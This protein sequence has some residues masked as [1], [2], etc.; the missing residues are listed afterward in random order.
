MDDRRSPLLGSFTVVVAACLFAM[1]GVLSRIAYDQGLTPYAFVTWRSGVAALAVAV[2]VLVSLR[3]GRRLVGWR[4]LTS[5]DRVALGVA[6]L[7]GASLDVTMFLAFARVPVAI[8]LLCFYLFP[9]MV[10]VGSALLGW[11]RIDRP[12]AMALVIALVGMVAVVIGGE[13]AGALGGLDPVGVLLAIGS[14]LSQ[15]VFVLVA[16]RGYREVPTDQAMTFILTVSASIATLLAFAAGALSSVWLPFSSPSLLGLLVF[17]GV[18][19]AGVPSFLF[20]AGIRW[21]GG[22]KA[23]ILMLAQ[24]PLAV[25]LAAI[26]LHE[27]IGPVQIAG[28]VGILAAAF[29]IQRAPAPDAS[30]VAAA[31]S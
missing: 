25:A 22:V 7:M 18:V 16:R 19:A 6:A 10:A 17:T 24:A 13:G 8:V 12:R 27:S 28:G 29:I 5:R 11:E 21:I 3:R 1:L 15:A 20:L 26:F 23:G 2:L 9:A 4:S 30:A 14:A 31:A